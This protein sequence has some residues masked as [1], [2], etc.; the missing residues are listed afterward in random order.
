MG[1]HARPRPVHWKRMRRRIRLWMA[2]VSA[3]A[4]WVGQ[5]VHTWAWPHN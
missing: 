3:T 5:M 4:F 2:P 1:K